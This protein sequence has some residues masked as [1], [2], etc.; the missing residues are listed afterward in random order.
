MRLELKGFHEIQRLKQSKRRN[1]RNKNLTNKLLNENILFIII[2]A[3][4]SITITGAVSGFTN[5]Q[6]ITAEAMNIQPQSQLKVGLSGNN[7]DLECCHGKSEIFIEKGTT[8]WEIAVEHSQDNEDPRS[9][10]EKI[11]QVNQMETSELRAGEII[12]LPE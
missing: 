8:M 12:T 11:K 7:K 10:I 2:L 5:F 6:E 4:I 3:V 1:N 9:Y